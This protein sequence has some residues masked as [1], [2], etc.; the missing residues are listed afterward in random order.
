MGS[1]DNAGSP[2]QSVSMAVWEGSN[3]PGMRLN[4]Q[5]LTKAKQVYALCYYGDC[6]NKQIRQSYLL[7]KQNVILFLWLTGE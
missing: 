6:F 1:S 2:A 3:L 4:L 7:E 5:S